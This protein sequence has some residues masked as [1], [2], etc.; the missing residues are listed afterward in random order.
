MRPQCTPFS[1]AASDFSTL[2]Q[3]LSARSTG[4]RRQ[5]LIRSMMSTISIE[6]LATW[7]PNSWKVAAKLVAP[8]NGYKMNNLLSLLHGGVLYIGVFLLVLTVLVFVHELGHYLVARSNGV[9]IEVF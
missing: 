2:R 3:P 1:R 9:K 5:I 6:P 4:F 8:I 7:R